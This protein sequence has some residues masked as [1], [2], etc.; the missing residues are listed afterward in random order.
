MGVVGLSSNGAELIEFSERLSEVAFD[1]PVFVN[2]IVTEK[3]SPA[4]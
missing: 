3:G 2:V 4:K 1:G